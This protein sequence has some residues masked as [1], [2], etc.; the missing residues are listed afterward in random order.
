MGISL[1]DLIL[2]AKKMVEQEAL[3][4]KKEEELKAEKENLR[5]IR[6]EQIPMAMKELE[7][8]SFTLESGEKLR[9]S[10]EVYVQIP[11]ENKKEAYAWL[12]E[13]GF[14]GV[15]KLSLGVEYGKG[16][17]ESAIALWRELESRGINSDLSEAVHPQTLKALLKEQIG[18]GTSVPLDLFGARPV[19]V[20]KIT[21]K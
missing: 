6:E 18:I 8:E 3:I 11:S 15:I 2:Y 10:Q 13:H 4:D 5:A 19:F 20:A 14:G 9:V 1:S 21:K 16:E 12:E 17:K 7:I